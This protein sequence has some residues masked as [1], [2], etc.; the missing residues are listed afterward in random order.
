MA[1]HLGG[2]SAFFLGILK[3]ANAVKAGGFE[4]S[5][6]LHEVLFGLAGEADDK[7]RPDGH[8]WYPD[9]HAA[10]EVADVIAAGLTLHGGEHLARDVLQRNVDVAG[11][12]LGLRDR[13]NQLVAPVR[14]VCVEQTD[15]IVAGDRVDF[16]EQGG[17]GFPFGRIDLAARVRTLLGPAIHTEVGGVLGD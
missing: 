16:T 9:A 8:V 6:E 10:D 5:E 17:D 15:P 7:G 13:L 3:D 2:L 12:M 14:R 11:D 1:L 4:E